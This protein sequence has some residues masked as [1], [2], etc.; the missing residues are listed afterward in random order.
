[1]QE[2]FEGLKDV[3]KGDDFIVKTTYGTY[4]YRVTKIEIYDEGDYDK[5]YD[6]SS[7][8]EQLILYTCYPFGDFNGDKTKRM[9]V[10]F[11]RVKGPDI[12][13]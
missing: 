12:I 3:E 10:Y 5:A 9:F 2:F 11:E 4:D 7:K 6:L 1:M 8:K 13:F